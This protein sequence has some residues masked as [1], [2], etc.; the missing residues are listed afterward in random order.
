LS[1]RATRNDGTTFTNLQTSTQ[2]MKFDISQLP[3]SS[4]TAFWDTHEVWFRGYTRANNNWRAWRPDVTDPNKL[5]P[6]PWQLKA[7]D[8]NG[9][10]N[11]GANGQT[12]QNGNTYTASFYEYDWKEG[13]GD[14]AT[15]GAPT[16]ITAYNAP[17]NK[18]YCITATCT[19][20]N[21]NT[22]G[23]FNEFD[24]NVLSLGTVPMPNR[25]VGN[26][27]PV[28]TAMTY[29]EQNLEDLV[30]AARDAGLDTITLIGHSGVDATNFMNYSVNYSNGLNQVLTSKEELHGGLNNAGQFSP[31]LIIAIP[32]PAS[33]AL[34][35]LACVAGL[36]LRRRK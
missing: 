9:T 34:I 13:T 3:N 19:T 25:L 15:T 32:E 4:D 35:G 28:R 1:T 7:L 27:L 10:Y 5:V 17:G 16:G 33:V 24:S 23:R 2:Y 14:D 12:D 20:A 26:N 36:G 6:F 11:N 22:L 21:G 31:Q 18:P 29:K 30:K 8:P